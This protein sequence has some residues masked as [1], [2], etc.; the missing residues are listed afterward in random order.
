MSHFERCHSCDAFVPAAV[1]A[2]PCC[3]ARH[4]RPSAPGRFGEL[5]RGVARLLRVTGAAAVAVTLM[6]CYGDGSYYDCY[7]DPSCNGDPVCYDNDDCTGG[8][9][10]DTVYNECEWSGWCADDVDCGDGFVC[11]YRDTCVPGEQPPDPCLVN[12]DCEV[13]EACD[14]WSGNCYYTDVCASDEDCAD[15]TAENTFCNVERSTC[16]PCP[17]VGCPVDPGFCDGPVLCEDLPPDC[18]QGTTAGIRDGCYTGECIPDGDCTSHCS[19]IDDEIDCDAEQACESTYHGVNCTNPEG[20]PCTDPNVQCTCESFVFD[21]C[22]AL[23]PPPDDG[24]S[25]PQSGG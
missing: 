13:G 8:Y 19:A 21:E 5:R 15:L 24:P 14:V 4:A 9:V 11:D 22:V 3:Q 1:D 20:G 2:C 6:A 18:A 10:C 16:E 23:P 25:D 7:D 12:D 17:E